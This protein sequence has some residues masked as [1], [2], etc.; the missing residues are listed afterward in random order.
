MAIPS[1]SVPRPGRDPDLLSRGRGRGGRGY[2]ASIDLPPGTLI[3]VKE[4]LV[5]GWSESQLRRKLGLESIRHILE[6]EDANVVVGCMEEL[7]PRRARVDDLMRRRRRRSCS[8][9]RDDAV[10]VDD[11]EDRIPTWP[12]R[13]TTK[14]WGYVHYCRIRRGN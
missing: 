14:P 7:H 10:A 8:R 13:I 9:S 1:P 4:P 5:D 3:L 6:G 12:G 2:V 11:D